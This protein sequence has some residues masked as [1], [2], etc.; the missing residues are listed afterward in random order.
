MLLTAVF[1]GGMPLVLAFN[2]NQNAFLTGG[3]IRAFIVALTILVTTALYWPALRHAA[4][5]RYTLA[6]ARSTDLLWIAISY[7]DFPCLLLAMRLTAPATAALC[8][9]LW[10]AMT[11]FL[12]A[13]TNPGRYTPPTRTGTILTALAITG[14]MLATAAANGTSPTVPDPRNIAGI[15][16]ALTAAITTSFTGYTWTWAAKASAPPEIQRTIRGV[17]NAPAELYFMLAAS[18][19][20]NGLIALAH[21]ATGLATGGTMQAA[22]ILATGSGAAL[23]YGTGSMLWRA[24]TRLTPSVTI[25]A[26]GSSTPVFAVAYLIA[27]GQA[28]TVNIPLIAAF[29]ILLTLANAAIALT[30]APRPPR[31]QS[32]TVPTNNE[33]PTE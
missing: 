8:Y 19:M 32:T 30:A 17:A 7:T 2:Q 26:I 29:A 14:A 21:T 18:V 20:M 5:W 31:D 33:A 1:M 10:P 25:H 16:L 3:V 15:A 24:S 27:A 22:R 4:T 12:I 9:E 23:S 13:R 6:R 11:M 28:G